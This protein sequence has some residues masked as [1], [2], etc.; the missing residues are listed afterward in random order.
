MAAGTELYLIGPGDSI[1]ICRGAVT[2]CVAGGCE[3]K[4]AAGFFPAALL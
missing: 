1:V 4:R 3:T 2:G